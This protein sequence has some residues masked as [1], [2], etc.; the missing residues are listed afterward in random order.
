[1]SAPAANARSLPPRTMQRIASSSS[2]SW[3]TRTSSSI[4]SPESAF[5]CSGRLS[6]TTA[7]G[8]SRPR[9]TSSLTKCADFVT[10]FPQRDSPW[11][12]P[13]G[14]WPTSAESVTFSPQTS[15]V[16]VPAA[17][18]EA[19][20][21]LLRLVAEHRERQPVA[22]VVDRLVPGE[23]APEVQLLLRVSRRLRELHGE[24]RGHLVDLRVELGRG[25]DPV[26]E[27]PFRGLG[28]RDLLAH[29]DDLAGAAVA[30][31]HGEPLRRAAGG[32]GAVLETDVADERVLD[33]H[34]QV[35]RH[36]QLVTAA[37]RAPV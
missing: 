19:P 26:D 33:H 22:R 24:L 14:T 5:S 4:S 3:S 21:R 16:C 15:C 27:P 34:R 29:E 18:D 17:G 6:S 20:H 10:F 32:D 37:D 2:S 9:T 7:I 1:M 23:V 31:E 11:T 35:A 25:N 28:G 13:V 36:L 12:W 30:D 8:S